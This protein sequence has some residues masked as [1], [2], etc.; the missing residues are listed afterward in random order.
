[1]EYV[2]SLAF[3]LF[4]LAV[5]GLAIYVGN[6]VFGPRI[7][8]YFQDKKVK[9]EASRSLASDEFICPITRERATQ[10]FMPDIDN[11]AMQELKNNRTTGSCGHVHV[12]D[13][14]YG[15]PYWLV[16]GKDTALWPRVS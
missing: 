9:A 14:P 6:R 8:A 11:L 15:Y 3:L 12:L 2:Y 16:D 13:S 10:S 7:N 1:M 4:S 5:V